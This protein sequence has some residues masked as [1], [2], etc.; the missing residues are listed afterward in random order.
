MLVTRAVG[1]RRRRGPLLATRRQVVQRDD[2]EGDA[3]QR[4]ARGR[5]RAIGHTHAGRFSHIAQATRKLKERVVE[6]CRTVVGLQVECG[7]LQP[8]GPRDTRVHVG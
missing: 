6:L 3:L 8:S 2:V 7:H 5:P 4:L 1:A